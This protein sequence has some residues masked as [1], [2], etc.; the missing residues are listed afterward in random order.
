MYE[1][2]TK[3][4]LDRTIKGYNL[5]KLFNYCKLEFEVL[6][7]EEITHLHIRQYLNFLKNKN[8]SETYINTILKNIRSFYAY[9]YKEEYC[10]NIAKKVSFLKD[11]KVIID[12]FTDAEVRKMLD[13][14]IR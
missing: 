7:L 5:N 3:N 12:S 1:I 14:Y 4:C 13:I 2:R 9:C 8:L 10:L 6:E 11:K